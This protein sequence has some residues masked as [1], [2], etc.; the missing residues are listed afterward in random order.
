[1]EDQQRT[2]TKSILDGYSGYVLDIPDGKKSILD[3]SLTKDVKQ[4]FK[5]S[6]SKYNSNL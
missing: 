4:N 5:R 6:R 1:M 3:S 2:T